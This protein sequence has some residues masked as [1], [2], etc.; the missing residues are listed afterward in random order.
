MTEA[1]WRT[2][3]DPGRMLEGLRTRMSDRQ[4]RLFA[5]AY[6]R[7]DHATFGRDEGGCAER[8]LEGL[9]VA[10]RWA[11][12]GREED[13]LRLQLSY[14]G[15]WHPLAARLAGDAANWTIRRAAVWKPN[16]AET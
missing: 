1:E 6:W 7:W 11:E 3:E 16:Q 14:F 2:S 12:D 4:L 13:P 10:E 9:A 15:G 5:C 8:I